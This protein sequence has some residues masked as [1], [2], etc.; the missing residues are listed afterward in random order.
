M[1]EIWKKNIK[2]GNVNEQ[3]LKTIWFDKKYSKIRKGLF[4]DRKNGICDNC[5]A[6]GT[7]YGSNYAS[8]FKKIL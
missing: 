6:A 4:S 7:L 8:S 5:D 2:F 3:E 1:G